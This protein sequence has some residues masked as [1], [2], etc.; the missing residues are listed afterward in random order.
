MQL[1]VEP[2]LFDFVNINLCFAA[3]VPQPLGREAVF[4]FVIS[5]TSTAI[6]FED[7]TPNITSPFLTIPPL[8]SGRFFTC[9]VLQIIG[10]N[11]VEG[12]EVIVSDLVPLSPQDSVANDSTLVIT[13]IDNDQGMYL[14]I[15][16]GSMG[17]ITPRTMATTGAVT[18]YRIHVTIYIAVM[19]NSLYVDFYLKVNISLSL[20]TEGGVAMHYVAPGL[21]LKSSSSAYICIFIYNYIP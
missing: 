7:Y 10:D 3:N 11:D 19:N 2:N 12:N 5:N 8:F 14:I 17:A 20:H 13:I 21:K 1:V 16:R 4:E 9:V 6:I 18:P 15:S